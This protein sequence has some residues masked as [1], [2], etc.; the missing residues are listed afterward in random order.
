MV[1]QLEI[2]H[3]VSE[4]A[5]QRAEPAVRP[6]TL[7]GKRVAL[8]WNKKGGG[9]VALERVAECFGGRFKDISFERISCD[10]KGSPSALEKVIKECHAVVG[11]TSD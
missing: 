8:W 6:R 4:I 11:T 10:L 7:E 9:D 3:P 5:T 2:L 1:V